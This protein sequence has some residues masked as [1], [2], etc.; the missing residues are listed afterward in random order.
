MNAKHL[1]TPEDHP[2]ILK[3]RVGVII[4]NLGGIHRLQ[5]AGWPD[6]LADP[7]FDIGNVKAV[8]LG[9]RALG[10]AVGIQCSHFQG[11]AQILFDFRRNLIEVGD[12]GA[13]LAQGDVLRLLSPHHWSRKRGG[14]HRRATC[15]QHGPTRIAYF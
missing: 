13:K 5:V 12:P 7:V 11:K 3:Q 1:T 2:K 14:R 6:F 8:R 9:R 15:F 10:H 4:G